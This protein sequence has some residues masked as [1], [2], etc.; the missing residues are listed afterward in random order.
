MVVDCLPSR[1][2][3]DQS[4]LDS[5]DVRHITNGNGLSHITAL[6]MLVSWCLCNED[7][8]NLP[9]TWAMEIACLLLPLWPAWV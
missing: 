8:P 7:R 1:F 9:P 5:L 6:Q 2:H 4:R 3:T